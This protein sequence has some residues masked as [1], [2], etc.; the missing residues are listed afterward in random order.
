MNEIHPQTPVPGPNPNRLR[1][2]WFIAAGGVLLVLLA[3]LSRRGVDKSARNE[4]SATASGQ[5]ASADSADIKPGFERIRRSSTAPEFTAEEIVAGKVSQFVRKRRDLVRAIGRR[6]NK[7]VPPEI[8]KFFD[9]LESGDWTEIEKQWKAISSRSAQYEGSTHSPELDPFWPA[10][11]DAYGVAEQAHMWPAQKLLDYG[12]AILDTLRP[13]MIYVGGTDPGRWIPELLNET[14]GGEQHIIVTQNAFADGRYMEFMNTLYSDRM[15]TLTSDDSKRA[16]DEYIADAKKRFEH[17]R[18]FPDEP[19][20]VRPGE[21]VRLVDG[22]IQV[23]GQVAVMAINEKMF[24]MLLDKNPG[25]SFAI[26]QSFPFK[27]T[28]ENATPLG[29]IMEVRVQDQQNALTP[30]RATE[31]VDYWRAAAQ[32]VLFPTDGQPLDEQLRLAYSKLASNQADLLL[33]R[34]Y[35]AQAEQTFQLATQISPSSP[36]AVYGY[37]N[38]LITQDR[39]N[40]AIP[41]AQAA[42]QASPDNRQFQDL[43]GQLQTKKRN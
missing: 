39:V 16:F 19:R 13:G 18:Q 40:D 10:V 9:A 43:L 30:E 34:N 5:V 23:S 6:E 33:N 7:E 15:S 28:Y 38:F 29:P 27:S 31:S 2:P 24:Q 42:I 21:D 3:L 8:E 20:Q 35:P 1:W 22:K 32:Q 26:E 17:D 14:S 11:L 25:V 4:T 41:I 12:N 36:E 37:I